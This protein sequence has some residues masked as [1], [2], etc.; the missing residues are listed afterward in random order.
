MKQRFCLIVLCALCVT[1]T[2]C[3][4]LWETPK[5]IWGSSIYTLRQGLDNSYYEYFNC[6]FEDCFNAIVTYADIDPSVNVFQKSFVKSYI[7][8]MGI[9][10]SVDTTE[11]GVFFTEVEENVIRVDISSLS[12]N[13]KRYGS[14]AVFKELTE[15][16]GVADYKE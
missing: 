6:D 12:S 13:A 5:I 16:Y 9:E 1:L 8:L 10:R 3:A 11:V 7:V 15:L 14:K 2:G 4:K